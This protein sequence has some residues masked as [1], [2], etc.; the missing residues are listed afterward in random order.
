MVIE[1]TVTIRYVIHRDCLD[2]TQ[3]LYVV[4]FFV[5]C[6]VE[7]QRQSMTQRLQAV[8]GGAVLYWTAAAHGIEREKE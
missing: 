4:L 1:V 5:L 6:K 7:G 2:G 3:S 8:G